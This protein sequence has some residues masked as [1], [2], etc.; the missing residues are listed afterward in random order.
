MPIPEVVDK[1]RQQRCLTVSL[2]FTAESKLLERR[3]E[4]Q[5]VEVIAEE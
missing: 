1:D 5:P 4:L 3:R 2:A